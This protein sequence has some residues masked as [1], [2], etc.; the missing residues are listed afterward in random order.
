[1]GPVNRIQL[2]VNQYNDDTGVNSSEQK[3]DST[4]KSMLGEMVSVWLVAKNR[5]VSVDLN[6]YPGMTVMQKFELFLADYAT[7]EP[8]VQL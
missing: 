1:M 7:P 4:L 3:I 6:K 8:V 2:F 5:F